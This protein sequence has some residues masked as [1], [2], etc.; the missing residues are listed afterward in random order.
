MADDTDT[1]EILLD[2]DAGKT[3]SQIMNILRKLRRVDNVT[4]EEA[5][6]RALGTQLYLLRK[7]DDGATVAVEDKEGRI[8]LDF[9]A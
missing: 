8:E 1:Y 6:Q 5:L 3:V 7:V 4:P 2:G 9:A